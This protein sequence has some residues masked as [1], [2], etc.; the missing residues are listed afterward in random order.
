MGL[1]VNKIT[2]DGNCLFRAVGDQ[3]EVRLQHVCAGASGV[4]RAATPA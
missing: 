2:A 3:L 1:R 4:Q